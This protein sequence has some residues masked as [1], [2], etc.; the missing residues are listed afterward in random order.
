M[1]ILAAVAAILILGGCHSGSVGVAG[2]SG[3]VSLLGIINQDWLTEQGAAIGL[4]INPPAA[5]PASG[6]TGAGAQ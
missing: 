2:I 1:R 3:G 6:S 4:K 5:T